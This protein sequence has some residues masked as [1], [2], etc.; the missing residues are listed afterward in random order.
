MIIVL[1]ILYPSGVLELSQRLHVSK[2]KKLK[3]NS[4]ESSRFGGNLCNFVF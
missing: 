1:K 3:I 2:I 4:F